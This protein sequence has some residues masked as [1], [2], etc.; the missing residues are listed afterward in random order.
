MK[1]LIDGEKIADEILE[2]LEKVESEPKLQIVLV[3]DSEAS[4][5]FVEEKLEAA[6][7]IGFR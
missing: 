7:K 2:E 6:E 4:Q 3:G 5:T 1:G